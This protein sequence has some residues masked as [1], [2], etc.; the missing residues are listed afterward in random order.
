MTHFDHF[1]RYPR[2]RSNRIRNRVRRER[3]KP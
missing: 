2:F 3:R 1:G